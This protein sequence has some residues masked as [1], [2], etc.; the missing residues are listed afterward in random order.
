ERSFRLASVLQIRVRQPRH[1]EPLLHS[2]AV[3]HR[4]RLQAAR[5]QLSVEGSESSDVSQMVNALNSAVTA[6]AD[7]I[8]I[9]LVD[10][11][12]FNKPVEKALA[13]GIPVVAYNADAPANKRL[14]YSGQDLK[15]AGEEMGARIIAVV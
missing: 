14:S 7:G 12:A 15:L 2:H 6:K 5:L 10:L 3:R 4:R 13:A 11:H 8:A 1:H 9:S